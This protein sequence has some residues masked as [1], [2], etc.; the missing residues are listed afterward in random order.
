[1][2]VKNEMSGTTT[3]KP[4]I[5]P[6]AEAVLK[7]LPSADLMTVMKGLASAAGNNNTTNFAK[8]ANQLSDDELGQFISQVPAAQLQSVLKKQ[9]ITK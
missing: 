1:M 8:P 7:K 2:E 4:V 3:P 9:G 5:T 6:E